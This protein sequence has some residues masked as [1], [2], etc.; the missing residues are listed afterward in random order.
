MY[1]DTKSDVPSTWCARSAASLDMLPKLVLLSDFLQRR[2][3][4]ELRVFGCC[5]LDARQFV[6]MCR[7]DSDA[8]LIQ[9]AADVKLRS[10]A[11]K[12]RRDSGSLSTVPP[13]SSGHQAAQPPDHDQ[14]I[15]SIVQFRCPVCRSTR[16]EALM[17]YCAEDADTIES[18]R[19]FSA[20]RS[21]T[22]K[23]S[24]L[25]DPQ[26]HKVETLVSYCEEDTENSSIAA[27]S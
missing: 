26:V 8:K 3:T 20:L 11:T 25:G 1:A 27:N 16:M 15:S 5:M 18:V 17:S 23:I 22:L 24:T 13:M 2:C 14:G 6:H 19:Q 10:F 4:I 21:G 7:E 12:V 9:N